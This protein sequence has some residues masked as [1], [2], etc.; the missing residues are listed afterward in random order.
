[1]G[2]MAAI[3]SVWPQPREEG[4]R[5]YVTANIFSQI[6][7]TMNGSSPT[8]KSAN[9]LPRIPAGAA[10][11]AFAMAADSGIGVDGHDQA[12]GLRLIAADGS[13]GH[14]EALLERLLQ[15]DRFH[16]GDLHR[17]ARPARA[18]GSGRVGHQRRGRARKSGFQCISAS[19]GA[20]CITAKR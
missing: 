15:V 19:H 17:F 4:S 13:V 16:L 12:R 6:L 14:P 11:G 10:S 9:P 20:Q 8:I 7:P 2:A 1:M 3:T 5:P 18:V